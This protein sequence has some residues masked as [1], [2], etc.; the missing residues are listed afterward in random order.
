MGTIPER[1][2]RNKRASIFLA[3]AIIL[4][5]TIIIAK[6]VSAETPTLLVTGT[7][8]APGFIY[9]GE[10]HAEE[11]DDIVMLQIT[12]STTDSEEININSIIIHRA[13]IAS[14]A[15]VENVDLYEDSNSNGSLDGA[16]Q[17]LSTVNFQVGRAEFS[18]SLNVSETNPLSLLVALDISS[19]AISG[20]TV[21]VEIP[22]QSYIDTEEEAEVEFEFHICSKNSTILLDTDGDLNPDSTDLDDDD[23]GYTD[24]NEQLCGS[25]PKD[26][27]SIPKDNDKDYV[28]DSIDTDDDNDGEPDEY[29]DFPLDASRQRDYTIIYVYAII[30]VVLII[31]LIFLGFKGKPRSIDK[32][33]LL[34]ET[35]E[36]EFD[37][38][39]EEEDLEA[40][41]EMFEDKELDEE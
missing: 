41:E 18:V 39:D 6:P 35:G 34:E 2:L 40:E 10:A 24:E 37:I 15:E 14:D 1:I 13:G 12:L 33:A 19:E 27:S 30:A 8:M 16:D 25:D 17:L 31:V 32:K 9:K 4:I 7:D 3:V 29:D 26:S 21:G 36:D 11:M 20:R 5:G 28:P 23:D 22:D 38:G